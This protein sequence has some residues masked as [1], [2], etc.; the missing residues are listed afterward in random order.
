[1][2]DLNKSLQSI[3]DAKMYCQLFIT[4]DNTVMFHSKTLP[5][6]NISFENLKNESITDTLKKHIN[7]LILL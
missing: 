5:S 1:M 2:M 6:Y 3:L 7:R 4:A